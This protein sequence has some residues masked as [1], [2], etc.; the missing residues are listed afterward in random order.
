[1]TATDRHASDAGA[2]LRDLHAR[3]LSWHE[4]HGD[5]AATARTAGYLRLLF[6]WGFARLGLSDGAR[7]FC[8][9]AERELADKGASHDLLLAGFTFRILQAL[10]DTDGDSP[11]PPD[12]DDKRR[13][14]AGVSRS[15]VDCMLETSR[16]LNPASTANPQGADALLPAMV[17]RL[18]SCDA[19]EIRGRLYE[20]AKAWQ[21]A[22]PE[23][24]RRPVAPPSHPLMTALG[25]RRTM[26]LLCAVLR[27]HADADAARELLKLVIE[28][29]TYDTT[30]QHDQDE[31]IH[32]HL[33][34]VDAICRHGLRAE[35]FATLSWVL[36][37][38]RTVEEPAHLLPGLLRCYVRG[39]LRLHL[40][41]EA[42]Q[43]LEAASRALRRDHELSEWLNTDET[44]GRLRLRCVLAL[45]NGW[46]AF[47]WG[48]LSRPALELAVPL[49]DPLSR[50]LAARAS[51]ARELVESFWLSDQAFAADRLGWL[52][53]RM[54]GLR[55][56]FPTSACFARFVVGLTESLVTTA[57]E[58]CRRR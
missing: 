17:E 35:L 16:V 43:F 21:Q 27:Q 42:D 38:C 22:Q 40:C 31:E 15:A 9:A 29:A 58:V 23:E 54:P 2:W 7:E 28:R 32:L 55:D 12:W 41:E 19:T 48:P 47:G 37:W 56:S 36:E 1:M 25:R 6:A 20:E 18:A 52:L 3:A 51:L 5:Y 39:L 34:A 13:D 45:A 11:L 14:L 49:L 30:D 50:P 4:R 46:H 57:V 10:A 26:R 8:R 33:A 53:E 44:R 24:Q